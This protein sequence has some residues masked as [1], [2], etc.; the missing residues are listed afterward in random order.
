M[1]LWRTT[2]Q[3]TVP[4]PTVVAQ[5]SRRVAMPAQNWR[6]VYE[7]ALLRAAGRGHAAARS[8]SQDFCF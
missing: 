2:S 8:V 3:H 4:R 1:R 5:R 7:L 6:E